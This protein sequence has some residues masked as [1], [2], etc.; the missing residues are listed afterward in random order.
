MTAHTET[1]SQALVIGGRGK[2]GRR[3][4]QRL[5]DQ[6]VPTR[7]GSRAAQPPFDWDD[8]ATWPAALREVRRVYL[9]FYPDLA[10]PGSAAKVGALARLARSHGVERLVMLSG[11]GEPEAQR[12]EH[13][14][15]DAFAAATIVRSSWFAQNF[16]ESFLLESVLRDEIAL[17]AGQAAEPF[18]DADDIADIAVAAL[19]D[20]GHEGRVYE[21]TGPR[22]LTFAEAA[23]EISTATGRDIR[24]HQITPEQ[25]AT[26][27]LEEHVPA[28]V[29]RLLVDLFTVT[30]DG[31]NGYVT[32]G[33]QQ[34][35]G[36][37]PRDFRD[38]ARDAAAGGV[39]RR[40]RAAATTGP[41]D[42][43]E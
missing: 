4:A 6:G 17:P 8:P 7:I 25:F 22:L 24:Y 9:T 32:D 26:E 43:G 31:H 16:S 21:V 15:R 41:G 20:D 42:R 1:H 39:W 5:R 29:V 35:L 30:L 11:R 19:T 34:A 2:T 12:S 3:V 23:E 38:Y 28:D 14:V 27:L 13:A 10:A 33:V 40:S 18:I 37:Q 36:R